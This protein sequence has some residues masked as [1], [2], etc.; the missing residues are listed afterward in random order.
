MDKEIK[1]LNASL[2]QLGQSN[3]LQKLEKNQLEGQTSHLNGVIQ[4]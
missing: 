2:Q 3:E 1:A 4:E